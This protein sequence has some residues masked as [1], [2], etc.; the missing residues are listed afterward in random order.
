LVV[1]AT[2]AVVA[3]LWCSGIPETDPCGTP[4]GVPVQHGRPILVEPDGRE[5]VGRFGCEESTGT[6]VAYEQEIFGAAFECSEDGIPRWIYV[7]C[8]DVEPGAEARTAIYCL[9]DGTL[10][11][12]GAP[13][14]IAEGW[15]RWELN[16]RGDLKVGGT[17]LLAFQHNAVANVCCSDD[18]E[19][20]V[21][22]DAA[23][24]AF[25]TQLP[26][27]V[28]LTAVEEGRA[29]SICC[30]Y[31]RA[32]DAQVLASASAQAQASH[33]SR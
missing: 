13:Q 15:N 22:Q 27:C 21:Y 12:I 2:I 5:K 30:E 11:A 33:A 14:V 18:P 23:A 17:Y 20:R 28:E 29:L 19:A 16:P 4:E 32:G 8:R 25:G 24:T 1:L 31:D 6:F 10:C 26:P 3:V 7:H 9:D